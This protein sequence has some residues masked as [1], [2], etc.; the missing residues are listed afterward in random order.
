MMKGGA[1]IVL[2]AYRKNGER[3]S[4]GNQWD[5]KEL[6]AIRSMEKFHCPECHEEVIM[7]LGSKKI[8]HFSH[9]SGSSC[10]YQY[11]RESEYH[12][13]GKLQLYEWLKKQ[14]INAELEKFDPLIRQKPDLAFDW[15]GMKYAIEFQCSIIPEELFLKRTKTYFEH[16]YIPIWIAAA[17]LIKRAGTYSVSMSN[18]LYLFIRR[19]L[20]T[21]NIPAY[22]P[23][24]RQFID[25]HHAIP[26]SS[27]KTLT[28]LEVH[29]ISKYGVNQ[30][31]RPVKQHP[32]FL[33]TWQTEL[34]KFKTRYLMFPGSRRNPFL[35]EIYKNRLNILLLPPELGLPV[36]S[37]PYIETPA[38]MWQT[39]LYLDVF[40]Y[41]KKGDLIKYSEIEGVFLYRVKTQQIQLRNLPVAGA[42][43][44][45]HALMEYIQLLLDVSV[46]LRTGPTEFIVNRSI[47]TPSSVHEQIEMEN[48]FNK[49]YRRMIEVSFIN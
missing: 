17:N 1:V 45:T 44:Y 4:L 48:I 10:Q 2:V 42:R 41:A 5:K 7:K 46:L 20:K 3:L 11:D 21:W 8:W 35:Q 15:H 30:L 19:P 26:I 22:C 13:S 34:K 43:N 23:L 47:K 31:I 37:S 28:H 25:L 33:K 27:R 32:P 29:S 18:F 38:L 36:F 39:Y 12:L 49:N 14:G 16:G 9:V 24:S 6:T 40:R